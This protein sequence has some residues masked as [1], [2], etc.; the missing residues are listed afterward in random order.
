M[1]I[2]FYCTK[3]MKP[4]FECECPDL[5]QRFNDRFWKSALYDQAMAAV[6]ENIKRREQL[7]HERKAV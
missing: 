3:C 5:E 6:D 1:P 7:V 2:K 4:V